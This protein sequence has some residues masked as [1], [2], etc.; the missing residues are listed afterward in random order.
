MPGQH[1]FVYQ[2]RLAIPFF[3]DAMRLPRNYVQGSK[4]E[5]SPAQSCEK[6]RKTPK[7]DDRRYVAAK[8]V[9]IAQL[10][11]ESAARSEGIQAQGRLMITR[12]SEPHSATTFGE[13]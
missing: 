8:L 1:L 7:D 12:G 6:P 11:I 4:R 9:N 2:T 10:A 3:L 5:L 13:L